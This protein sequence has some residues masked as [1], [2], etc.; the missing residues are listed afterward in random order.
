MKGS[1]GLSQDTQ[2]LRILVAGSAL[3][4]DQ[5]IELLREKYQL[6]AIGAAD[7]LDRYR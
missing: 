7:I 2:A 1:Q 4:R 6:P 3:T 5:A